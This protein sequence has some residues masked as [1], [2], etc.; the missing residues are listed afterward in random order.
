MD[1]T[2]FI[3]LFVAAVGVPVIAGMGLLGLLYLMRRQRPS[4]IEQVR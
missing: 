3:H 1:F 2:P 4:S